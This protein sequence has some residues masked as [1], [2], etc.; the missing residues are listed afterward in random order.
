MD[1]KKGRR[2]HFTSFPGVPEGKESRKQ[3]RG[4]GRKTQFGQLRSLLL[5]LLHCRLSS[6]FS[7]LFFLGF[8]CCVS[9]SVIVRSPLLSSKA[10]KSSVPSIPSLLSVQLLFPPRKPMEAGFLHPQRDS[11]YVTA[12]LSGCFEETGTRDSAAPRPAPVFRVV[13]YCVPAC[14]TQGASREEQRERENKKRDKD[15][16]GRSRG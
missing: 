13:H 4:W 3:E 9:L 12:A 11:S 5:L 14:S 10:L 7:P 6:R 8:P 1:G 2:R 15:R 16:G